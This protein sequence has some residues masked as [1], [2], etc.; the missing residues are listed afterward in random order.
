MDA[1]A[2][3]VYRQALELWPGNGESL[4]ALNSM[5]WDRSDF[6]GVLTMLQPALDAD[7]NNIALWQMYLIAEKRKELQGAIAVGEET[8]AKQPASSADVQ[9]LLELY[10]SAGDTNKV[11]TLL[12]NSIPL[13]AKDA[14]FLKVAAEYGEAGGLPE[15][16]LAAAT[17][18]VALEPDIAENQLALARAALRNNKKT[19]FFSAARVAV[20]KGGLP[21]REVLAKSRE[22]DP[23][24]KEPEFQTILGQ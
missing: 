24:R 19:E 9:K 18:L 1:E 6:D 20:E 13:L 12:G 16:E 4:N 17:A 11:A 15:S 3:R 23:L 14:A 22:F 5:L 7:P 8:V 21:M 10:A 2:E